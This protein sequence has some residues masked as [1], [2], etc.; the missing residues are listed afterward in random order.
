MEDGDGLVFL[1]GHAAVD[2]A[3][4]RVARSED[5]SRFVFGTCAHSDEAAV[6]GK[7]STLT[8]STS[9]AIAFSR[10]FQAFSETGMAVKVNNR[11]DLAGMS[12]L[13]V[14]GLTIGACI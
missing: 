1:I 5:D 8:Q 12:K 2:A 14:P 11:G 3:H 6:S 9:D 13:E 4:Q 7:P 10:S